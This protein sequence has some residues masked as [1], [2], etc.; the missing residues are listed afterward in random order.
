VEF[1][2]DPLPLIAELGRGR[3]AAGVAPRLC[4]LVG[5][6]GE[7]GIE[8]RLVDGPVALAAAS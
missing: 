2:H 1:R 4:H 8:W 6:G 3:V 7:G 5:C